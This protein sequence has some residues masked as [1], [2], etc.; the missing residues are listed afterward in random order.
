MKPN[1]NLIVTHN[2]KIELIPVR[3]KSPTDMILFNMLYQTSKILEGEA[4]VIEFANIKH[5]YSHN[6][7]KISPTRKE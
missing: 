6:R 3:R 7:R 5:K 1:P 2:L 4:A